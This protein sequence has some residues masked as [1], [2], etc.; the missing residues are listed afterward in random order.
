MVGYKTALNFGG[1]VSTQLARQPVPVPANKLRFPAP[2]REWVATGG[3]QWQSRPWTLRGV[4]EVDESGGF[5]A[6][7]RDKDGTVKPHPM[8]VFATPEALEAAKLCS[9][10]YRQNLEAL[11]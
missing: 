5:F 10:L 2:I 4:L 1:K 3:G 11:P 7:L 9:Q 8:Y 6:A